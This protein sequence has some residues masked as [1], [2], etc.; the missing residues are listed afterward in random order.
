M[1]EDHNQLMSNILPPHL[2]TPP[3]AAM[4]GLQFRQVT[5]TDFQSLHET[6]YADKRAALFWNHF[7]QMMVWQ[8]NGRACWLLIEHDGN[9]VGSG[10]LILYPHGTELANLFV[11]PPYRS[12]GIGTAMI[13]ILSRIARHWELTDLEIGVAC[14]NE[15][16]LAL[17][18]RLGFTDDREVKLPEGGTAV[19]L[20]KT[21]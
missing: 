13:I 10:E 3:L 18:R 12:R 2:F 19:I 5:P 4:E 21:L 11:I 8:G 15:R 6:C 14:Q 20:H 17:Y 16:A 7:E 1:A 9:L